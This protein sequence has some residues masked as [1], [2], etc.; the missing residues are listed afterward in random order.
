MQRRER[1]SPNGDLIRWWGRGGV[2]GKWTGEDDRDHDHLDDHHDHYDEDCEDDDGDE[3]ID[4]YHD[5]DDDD[6]DD[7]KEPEYRLSLLLF[8]P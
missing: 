4:R 1:L 8:K 2:W 5:D 7:V 6:D 3:A